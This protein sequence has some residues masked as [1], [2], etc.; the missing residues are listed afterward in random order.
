MS[1]VQDNIDLKTEVAYEKIL[2]E[3]YDAYEVIDLMKQ[4][5][6]NNLSDPNSMLKGTGKLECVVGIDF[7]ISWMQ[8]LLE[9]F[10]PF[11]DA[12]CIIYSSDGKFM[13]ASKHSSFEIVSA[14]G[15][16]GTDGW[17]MHD[18][19]YI[20]EYCSGRHVRECYRPFD[21]YLLYPGARS[22]VPG[23]RCGVYHRHA[24]MPLLYHQ[25]GHG[26]YQLACTY[27]FGWFY[28]AWFGHSQDGDS[29][30][31]TNPLHSSW[32]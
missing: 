31:V 11:D 28:C 10:K 13:V 30:E 14:N 25:S 23:G 24:H 17:C 32:L 19:R 2:F 22:F 12:V 29:A 16:C 7:S 5:V 4:Y 21:E 26:L 15:V 27:E 6:T 3:L 20:N 8:D 9:E 1:N 18:N